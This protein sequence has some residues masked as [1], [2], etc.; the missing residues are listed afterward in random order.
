MHGSHP[1][2]FGSIFLSRFDPVY[3]AANLDDVRIAR[4]KSLRY[5]CR[6]YQIASGG[7]FDTDNKRS[8]FTGGGYN[9]FC[10][11]K[12]SKSLPNEV[13]DNHSTS[14]IPDHGRTDAKVSVL[15]PTKCKVPCLRNWTSQRHFAYRD[16]VSL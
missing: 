14:F 1:S 12:R 5:N 10:E 15:L 9:G 11:V 8:P 6:L 7:I 16:R 4:L 2:L 13:N 3:L